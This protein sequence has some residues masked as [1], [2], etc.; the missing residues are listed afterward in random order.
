[1]TLLALTS[2]WCYAEDGYVFITVMESLPTSTISFIRHKIYNL[3]IDFFKLIYS[4]LSYGL[5]EI[6]RYNFL[7]VPLKHYAKCDLVFSVFFGAL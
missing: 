6:A 5:S 7:K 4:P 1:M 3:L 2:L